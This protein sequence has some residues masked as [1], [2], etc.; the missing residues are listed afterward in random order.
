MS[1]NDLQTN[2]VH[3][4]DQLRDPALAVF[5]IGR[6]TLVVALASGAVNYAPAERG[7]AMCAAALPALGLYLFCL[8]RLE[9]PVPVVFRMI[10]IL[11]IG[12]GGVGFG[13]WLTSVASLVGLWFFITAAVCAVF[14]LVAT[15]TQVK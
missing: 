14:A 1:E 15:G 4:H 8:S 11:G 6:F 5:A 3:H 13:V 9:T 12:I 10:A 2:K 7:L